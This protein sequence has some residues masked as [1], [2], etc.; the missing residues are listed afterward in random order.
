MKIT[1]IQL[2]LGIAVGLVNVSAN[3]YI[4]PLDLT[5]HDFS[6]EVNPS[7]KPFVIGIECDEGNDANGVT[8]CRQHFSNGQSKLWY[9]KQQPDGRVYRYDRYPTT[10]VKP[11]PF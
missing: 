10:G 4:E 3:A 1:M 7:P 6:K 9:V 5:K 11:I 2:T 8:V